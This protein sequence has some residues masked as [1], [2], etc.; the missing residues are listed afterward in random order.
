[1]RLNQI[2]EREAFDPQC[3]VE[4]TQTEENDLFA[5]FYSNCEDSQFGGCC[6]CSQPSTLLLVW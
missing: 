6:F 4:A 1:L 2:F 5:V 3:E